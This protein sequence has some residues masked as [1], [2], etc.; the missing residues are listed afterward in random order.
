MQEQVSQQVNIIPKKKLLISIVVFLAC[1]GLTFLIVFLNVKP[2]VLYNTIHN[3]NKAY[4]VIGL[5]FVL[6]YTI[7]EGY[8]IKRLLMHLNIKKSLYHCYKYAIIG[9]FFSGITPSSTGGQ[10]MQIYYM[11]SEDVPIAY[12]SFALFTM[13]FCYQIVIG[14]Y[15]AIGYMINYSELSQIFGSFNLWLG[16]SIVIN[17]TIVFFI[18]LVIFK[19]QI[20]EK[21]INFIIS[22]F[23]KINNKFGAKIEKKL[24]L[25][26]INYKA[27]SEY[28]NKDIRILFRVLGTAF[29]QYILLYSIP[30]LVYKGLGLQGFPVIPMLMLQAVLYVGCGFIPTPGALAVTESLFVLI[31]QHYYPID[32]IGNAMVISRT[33]SLYL[34]VMLYGLLSGWW[35]KTLPY[36]KKKTERTYTSID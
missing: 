27:C 23:K 19:W 15:G 14:L 36:I 6:I 34:P 5:C 16:I 1:V 4:L 32:L 8:N 17:F 33:M 21:L 30:F 24:S 26:L 31:F 7:L 12:S 22:V 11:Y 13:L 18:G 3:F 2:K 20:A 28:L 29:L 25:F 35:L 10:P 9:F